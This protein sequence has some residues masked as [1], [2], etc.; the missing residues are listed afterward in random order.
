VTPELMTRIQT[1]QRTSQRVLG[2]TS[3]DSL[4]N[5]LLTAKKKLASNLSKPQLL[6]IHFH[7]LRHWK[8]T[9]YAHQVKDP[10]MVQMFAR[11][12]DLKCTSRYIHYEKIVYVT[13]D[14]YEWTVRAAKTVK[15]AIELIK[16]GFEYHVE[17]DGVKLFRKRK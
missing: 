6:K 10:F 13:S 1:L 2:N 14:N 12:K 17:I 11:H 8:L 16:V 5:M 3:S 9:N 4:A 15:E 7:T